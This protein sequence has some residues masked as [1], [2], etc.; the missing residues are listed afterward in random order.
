VED[1]FGA[2]IEP[3]LV[4]FANLRAFGDGE[5]FANADS[6]TAITVGGT[7]IPMFL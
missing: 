3:D 7:E 4:K 2:T 1:H 6:V 5:F